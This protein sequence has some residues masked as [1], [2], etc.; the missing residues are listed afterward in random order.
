MANSTKIR[1]FSRLI[2]KAGAPFWVIGP[3]GCLVFLSAAVGDWL[4]VEPESLIGRRCVAG[5]SITD[6]PLDFLAASLAPPPGF[7]NN[8]TASLLVQPT[9]RGAKARRIAAMDTRF[10]RLG[11]ADEAVTLAVA[12]SFNDHLADPV[13]D[14]AVVLR[15]ELD[16]WRRHHESIAQGVLVG[17]SRT[18]Q[19]LQKQTRL[20]G[21]VR[22]DLLILSPPGCLA[23][24]LAVSLHQSSAA[25]EPH[26][27]IDGPLMDP[28]LLDASLAAAIAHL[29][30]SETAKASAIVKDLDQM[31]LEAQLR[32]G[33]H[34]RQFDPRLRLIAIA[35]HDAEIAGDAAAEP[36]PDLDYAL[37]QSLPVGIAAPLADQLCG[38]T[39]RLAPLCDRVADLPMI[40]T[41][42]L[43]RRRAGGD[44]VADRFSRAALD[45]IVIYPWPD[46]FRELDQA[47]RHAT[48]ACPAQV[49][50]LEHLPLAIRSYRPNETV[51]KQQQAI[52]LDQAVAEFEADLIREA[53][54]T[55]DG[56]RAEAARRL[57]IS[58]ARLLRKLESI[59]EGDQ[60]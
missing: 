8:G 27:T 48:R 54:E 45:A 6:D 10:V 33:E 57:N 46:N 34:L 15:R 9:F 41:A 13:I 43:D 18:A 42:M 35:D 32:L 26:A 1:P 4:T 31:P 47:I 51:P 20:A 44:G 58:R 53:L 37:D 59:G 56:N 50:G 21:S 23:E 36:N 5:S 60:P 30:D 7:A 40:A 49:I 19:R 11:P 16:R 38:L 24:S 29:A 17:S 52:D 2:D 39:I 22:S 25:G 55:S 28:E 12:G 3:D 14:A